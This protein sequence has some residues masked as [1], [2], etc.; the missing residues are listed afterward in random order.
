MRLETN[1][2]IKE[3]D[4]KIASATSTPPCSEPAPEPEVRPKQAKQAQKRGREVSRQP[5]TQIM[6]EL[7]PLSDY[8]SDVEKGEDERVVVIRRPPKQRPPK[9]PQPHREAEPPKPSTAD[10]RC[11][12]S[13]NSLFPSM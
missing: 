13:Y 3:A 9:R 1:E 10:V 5:K 8:E 4:R 6:L 7:E 11:A 12:R 2:R